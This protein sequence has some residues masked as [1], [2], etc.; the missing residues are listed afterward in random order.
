VIGCTQAL[1]YIEVPG[2][3]NGSYPYKKGDKAWYS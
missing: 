1:R 3:F 2:S